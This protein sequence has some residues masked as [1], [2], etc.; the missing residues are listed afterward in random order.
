MYK[1]FEKAVYLKL[2][3]S[4]DRDF[5]LTDDAIANI[6]IT[7]DGSSTGFPSSIVESCAQSIRLGSPALSRKRLRAAIKKIN[8]KVGASYYLRGSWAIRLLPTKTDLIL[9]IGCQRFSGDNLTALCSWLNLPRPLRSE[10]RVVWGFR[11]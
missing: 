5:I 8:G 3:H 10:A 6:N 9:A 2:I 4:Q 11:G 7:I 1:P